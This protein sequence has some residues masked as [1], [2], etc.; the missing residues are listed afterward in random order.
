ML[1]NCVNKPLRK[2]EIAMQDSFIENVVEKST[3][4]MM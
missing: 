1:K 3:H 4:L 2:T